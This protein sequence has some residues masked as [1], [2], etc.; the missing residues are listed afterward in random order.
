MGLSK[1][2]EN[3]RSTS[4]DVEENNA[5]LRTFFSWETSDLHAL[6][7]RDQRELNTPLSS[8]QRQIAPTQSQFMGRAPNDG[9]TA[10]SVHCRSG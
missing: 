4:R 9:E 10:Y 3:V 5:T 1:R 8:R 6:V 7:S 2:H